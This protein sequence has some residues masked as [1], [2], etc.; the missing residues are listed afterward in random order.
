MQSKS[1]SWAFLPVWISIV[2]QANYVW[3]QERFLTDSISIQ[4]HFQ[5]ALSFKEDKLDSAIISLNEVIS[6]SLQLAKAYS[7]NQHDFFVHITAQSFQQK[8]AL[9]NNVNQLDS[10]YANL[11]LSKKLLI[12]KASIPHKAKTK[13]L[14]SATYNSLGV[15]YRKINSYKDALDNYQ[16]SLKLS[17]ELNDS[18]NIAMRYTNI[19]IVYQETGDLVR[20]KEYL[21]KALNIHRSRNYTIGVIATTITL[22][23]INYNNKDYEQ[24][25][26]LLMSIIE[27]AKALGNPLHIALILSNLGAANKSLGNIADSRANYAEALSLL[28]KTNNQSGQAMV[29]GNMADIALLQGNYV[30]ALK[31]ANMQLAI[32]QKLPGLQ[33]K[34]Y[35]YK[36]LYNANIGLQNYKKAV[37]YLELYHT[38]QDSIYSQ[39]K[40][41]EIE[42]LEA[43][44]QSE[45]KASEIERLKNHNELL[46]EKNRTRNALLIT[47]LLLFALTI[48][49]GVS[50]YRNR[51]LE[52]RKNLSELN[53]KLLL[54]QMNPHFIFNS[55]VA[56]QALIGKKPEE[57]AHKYI[58]N[59]NRLLRLIL[60]N[61]RCKLI[62]MEKEL[63]TLRLYI[64]AQQLRFSSNFTH[65]IILPDDP[66]FLEAMIPP[67]IAQPFV[68]NAIEHG[69]LR[70]ER[71]GVLI[72]RFSELDGCICCE[73][74][75]NGI[76][77]NKALEMARNNNHQSLALKITSERLAL[78]PNQ[79]KCKA[80]VS[81]E[82][83]SHTGK[84][85]TL[86]KIMIP[87]QIVI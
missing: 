25:R 51:Q 85:G 22:S 14:L 28:Q 71:G 24:A 30:E 17:E 56:I 26:Q 4:N 20:A 58:E 75:D 73:V 61:S 63:E 80:S 31:Y 68:E 69:I 46:S 82:D 57:I 38:V 32:A 48:I 13:E 16:Q 64:E 43:Q 87:Q 33:N 8:G 11:N 60:E 1:T 70:S 21:D 50:Y 76:G 67:M 37:E 49:T 7:D 10:A 52:A 42:K 29:L 66:E 84:S 41:N 44:Y 19:G 62:T 86:V 9:F 15:Y 53:Y 59:F 72:I 2:F 74:E 6:K 81:I 27:Q 12:E 5:E 47:I 35:A 40:M 18:L 34:R 65:S 45:K 77:I 36:H 79:G 3:A 78:L 55:L 83:L 23:N 54:V 39:E